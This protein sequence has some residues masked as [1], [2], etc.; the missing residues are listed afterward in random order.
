MAKIDLNRKTLPRFIERVQLIKADT[1]RQWGKMDA[2]RAVR[3]LIYTLELSLGIEKV[4]NRVH[5]VV[6]ALLYFAFNQ[7]IT[8]WPKGMKGPDY[9]T[10]LPKHDFASEK[11]QL[12]HL[13]TQFVNELERN[14][15][16]IEVN[17]S[18]GAITLAKWSRAHGVHMDHHLRQFGV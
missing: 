5:P 7:V 13:I 15:T 9:L 6:G 12:V 8:T 17:P 2:A 16:R 1:P 14:P 18:L 4:E 11:E 3:H 10:P